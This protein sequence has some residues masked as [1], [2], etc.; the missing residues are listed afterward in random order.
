[1]V[2]GILVHNTHVVKTASPILPEVTDQ[3]VILLFRGLYRRCVVRDGCAFGPGRLCL[4]PLHYTTC[5]YEGFFAHVR[6]CE[7]FAG[8]IRNPVTELVM[9]H[10]D[11]ATPLTVEGVANR[12]VGIAAVTEMG[13]IWGL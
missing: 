2:L 7:S 5:K 8:H 10:C 9:T 6:G 1:M 4:W 12:K 13:D 3:E 11:E